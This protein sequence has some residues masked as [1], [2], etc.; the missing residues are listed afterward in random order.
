[1]LAFVAPTLGK[2]LT[3]G[4]LALCVLITL[5]PSN[6]RAVVLAFAAGAGL[7]YFLELWGTTRA[8]WTYYTGATPPLFA[9]LAHGMAAVAFW[10]TAELVRAVLPGARTRGTL[11]APSLSPGGPST[12]AGSASEPHVTPPLSA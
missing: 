5:T 1:M 2:S 6:A 8:C 10:R 12:E 7:G 3:W 9:V 4:A 11:P